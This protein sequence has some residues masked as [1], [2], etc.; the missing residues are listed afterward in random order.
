MTA[1]ST[2]LFI[3]YAFKIFEFSFFPFFLLPGQAAASPDF[4]LKEGSKILI[5]ASQA[6]ASPA[7]TLKEGGKI[8]FFCFSGRGFSRLYFERRR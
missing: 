7:S 8:L 3:E 4:T 6:A 1:L 2:N 5:Q